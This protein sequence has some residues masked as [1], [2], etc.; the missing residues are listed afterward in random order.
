[1]KSCHEFRAL[2]RCYPPALACSETTEGQRMDIQTIGIVGAGRWQRHRPMLC[3]LAAMN[4]LF[5]MTV[6]AEALQK[7]VD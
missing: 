7:A 6:S 5:R 2:R 1:M 3:A 4:V